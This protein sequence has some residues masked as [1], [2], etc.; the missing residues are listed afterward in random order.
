MSLDAIKGKR[1]AFLEAN[2]D[3]AALRKEMAPMNKAFRKGRGDLKKWNPI[4]LDMIDKC[5]WSCYTNGKSLTPYL[6]FR[7]SQANLDAFRKYCDEVDRILL[8]HGSGAP[9]HAREYFA[10]YSIWQMQEFQFPVP[11]GTKSVIHALD[12]ILLYLGKGFVEVSYSRFDISLGMKDTFH[13]RDGPAHAR[14]GYGD[15]FA[16]QSRCLRLQGGCIRGSSQC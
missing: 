4:L 10:F 2:G 7:D 8:D 9:L 3:D 14:G 13:L 1:D 11:L 12:M 5:F 16:G 15:C 6:F